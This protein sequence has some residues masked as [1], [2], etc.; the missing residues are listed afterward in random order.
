MS[1]MTT[2]DLVKALGN[3]TAPELGALTK[4][5]ESEWNVQAVP[6]MSSTPGQVDVEP[7][8]AEQTEFTVMLVSF[9]ADKKMNVVKAVRDLTGLGLMESKTLV[10][11]V[12]TKPA[13]IKDGVSK[14]D[15]ANLNDKLTAAGGVVVVS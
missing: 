8:K 12:A 7:V 5:L 1:N 9:P 11:G 2:D 4:R 15:A 10:E 13:L 3:L 14:E 6:Q